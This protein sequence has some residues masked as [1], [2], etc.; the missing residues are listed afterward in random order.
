MK[1]GAISYNQYGFGGLVL[2]FKG[3]VSSHLTS[4]P[5]SKLL[6][7]AYFLTAVLVLR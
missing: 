4:D 7:F 6:M 3:E 1:H 5:T 2:L